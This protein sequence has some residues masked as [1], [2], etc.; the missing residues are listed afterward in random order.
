[1]ISEDVYSLAESYYG[2]RNLC[3]GLEDEVF[4]QGSAGGLEVFSIEDLPRRLS[5][6]SG[7][8]RVGVKYLQF[9][10]TS[11]KRENDQLRE[12]MQR[13]YEDEMKDD[14]DSFQAS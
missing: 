9:A 12:I 7:A 1:M 10:V 4:D 13:D 6:V 14:D 3:L 8:L 2:L 5:D 11:G